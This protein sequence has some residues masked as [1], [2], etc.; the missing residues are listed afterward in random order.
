VAIKLAIKFNDKLF[1]NQ[2]FLSY[3]NLFYNLGL[4]NGIDLSP[5]K[6]PAKNFGFVSLVRRKKEKKER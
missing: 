5:H 4:S 1:C 2:E 3:S 6:S